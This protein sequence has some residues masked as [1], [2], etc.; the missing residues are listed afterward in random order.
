MSFLTEMTTRR[1]ATLSRAR[2]AT[3]PRATFTTSVYLRKN[4]VDAGKDTLKTVDRAVSDK[5]V[6][7]IDIGGTSYPA[8]S[9]CFPA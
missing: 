6:D 8:P 4:V 5:L 7:G 9:F 2:F 3:V 1:M